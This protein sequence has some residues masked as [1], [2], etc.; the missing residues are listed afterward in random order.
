VEFHTSDRHDGHIRIIEICRPQ[1]RNVN[2]MNKV[3]TDN[4][5]SVVGKDDTVW[6]H[7]DFVMSRKEETLSLISELNGKIILIAGNHDPMHPVYDKRQW[8]RD[9]WAQRYLDAGVS[10]IR[11]DNVVFHKI[12]GETVMMSHFPYEGDHTEDE[13]YGEYRP[14][15]IGLTLIHGHVHDAW[16]V[17]R[18]SD[19]RRTLMVNVGVDVWDFTPVSAETLA[20]F[21]K[22]Q[23]KQDK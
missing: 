8:K 17:R 23:E 18:T 4:W 7:G 22:E 19:W 12:G 11:I 3:M 20:D 9:E 1:F 10:E 13:R 15:N 6:V 16:K 21:I 2:E 5:N 14:E